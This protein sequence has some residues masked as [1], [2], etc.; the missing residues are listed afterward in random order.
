M[1][2]RTLRVMSFNIRGASHRDG[3]NVWEG[4]A[5]L[6]VETVKRYAPDLIGLQEL[7]APNLE[8]YKEELPGYARIM[9]P[10]YGTDAVEEFAA[11][12]YD[13]ERF[14]KLDFGGFWLSDTPDESSASWGNEVVRSANWAVLRDRESGVTLLHANT[15]LDHLSERARVEGNRLIVRQTE[16][17][18]TNHGHPPTIITGDFNCKPGSA[19]YEVFREHDFTDTF[20]A[21]GNADD[22]EA[23]TFHVFKGSSFKPSDTDKPFGRIDWILLRDTGGRLEVRS[24]QIPRDAD[25]EAGLYPSDHYPVLADLSTTE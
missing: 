16:E 4:R 10:A 11:I 3:I 6:N 20:L 25:E 7:H 15:H 14:E 13:A 8:V 18:A 5:A 17:T 23:F 19:P 21:A 2:G 1:D 22:D 24:H 12:F 9:G